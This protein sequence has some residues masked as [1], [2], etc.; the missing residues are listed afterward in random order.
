MIEVRAVTP[1]E[2][3][4]VRDLRLAALREA[5]HAFAS[6][7]EQEAG[8]EESRWRARAAAVAWFTAWRDGRPVGIVAGWRR[9]D[10]PPDERHVISMWVEPAARGTGVAD[11]LILAVAGWAA[12]QGAR[13][14][15]LWVADSSPRAIA[16]YRRLGFVPTGVRQP[17]PSNP[18][19]GETELALDLS[20]ITGTGSSGRRR[21]A[22]NARG[23]PT[24]PA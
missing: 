8:L 22:G 11:A 16:F 15:T 7:Y 17:L 20:R 21:S 6:T 12:R 4:L 5:P 23:S 24:R 2:W 9:D 3:G 1:A 19:V 13:K 10:D 14:L 18:D